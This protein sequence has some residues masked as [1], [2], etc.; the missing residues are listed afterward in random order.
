MS[1]AYADLVNAK[2]AKLLDNHL[3]IQRIYDD[4]NREAMKAALRT[5][6]G[7]PTLLSAAPEDGK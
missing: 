5:L 2:L 7:L 3:Q 6:L 1:V 4:A